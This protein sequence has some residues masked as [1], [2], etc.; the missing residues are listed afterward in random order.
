[1]LSGGEGDDLLIGG[2]TAYDQASLQAISIYW[3]GGDDYA[4]RVAKITSGTG[5]PALNASTVSDNA[6]VNTLTGGTELDLFF[7]DS[8]LDVHDWNPATESFVTVYN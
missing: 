6:G 4:T 2:N 1:V 3:S 7:G 5:V 8:G